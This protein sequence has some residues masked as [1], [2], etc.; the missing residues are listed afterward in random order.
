MEEFFSLPPHPS[1]FYSPSK[2]LTNARG[3]SFSE[4]RGGQSVNVTSHQAAAQKWE[5]VR[6]A[7]V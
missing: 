2:I 7:Q 3:R 1:R 4:E 6:T 5:I